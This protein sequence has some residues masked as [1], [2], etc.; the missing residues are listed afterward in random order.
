MKDLFTDLPAMLKKELQKQ[1]KVA[2][3]P[4]TYGGR[5][6]PIKDKGISYE[7]TPPI[8]SGNLYNNI[9][10]FWD[11]NPAGEPELIVEMPDYWLWVNDGRRP[12]KYPPLG[13]ID[14]W[15]IVKRLSGVR[16]EKGRFIPRKTINFLRARSIAKYGYKGNNFV[17]KAIQSLL[18]NVDKEFGDAARQYVE[19]IL[20]EKIKLYT[21]GI[22][23]NIQL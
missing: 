2:R 4:R 6:K 9:D 21:Q 20:N 12:G 1:L 13:V 3:V 19:D 16:D 17:D 22:E 15:S 23:I 7:K 5:K 10:A 8:A 18:K 11:T 14:R